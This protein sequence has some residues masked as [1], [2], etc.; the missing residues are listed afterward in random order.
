MR[1]QSHEKTCL[2]SHTPILPYTSRHLYLL[3]KSGGG[4]G[5]GGGGWGRP[6]PPRPPRR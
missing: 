4:G 6:T 5:G 1:N 3:N 2:T